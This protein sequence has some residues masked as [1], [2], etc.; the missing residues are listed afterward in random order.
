V[1]D[2]CLVHGREGDHLQLISVKDVPIRVSIL[3]LASQ[4]EDLVIRDCNGGA[5]PERG[6]E[7]DGESSPDVIGGR[8]LFNAV[9]NLKIKATEKAS[10]GIDA[11]FLLSFKGACCKVVSFLLHR[12]NILPLL[13]VFIIPLHCI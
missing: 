12:G 5:C 8:V 6:F 9:I 7:G 13:L 10:K 1:R 3:V 11:F 2:S 4:D